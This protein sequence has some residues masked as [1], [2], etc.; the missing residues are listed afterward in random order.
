MYA[1]NSPTSNDSQIQICKKTKNKE[2]VKMKFINFQRCQPASVR[3]MDNTQ[4]HFGQALRT[5]TGTFGA[6]KD[7]LKKFYLF[8]WKNF[9]INSICVMTLF[10]EGKSIKDNNFRI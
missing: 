7:K 3:L 8:K 9:D 6:F 10:F 5:G 2:E 4:F 1:R